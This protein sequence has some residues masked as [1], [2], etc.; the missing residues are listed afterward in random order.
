MIGLVIYV[1]SA[2]CSAPSRPG[3]GVLILGNSISRES[4]P[5]WLDP[6]RYILT[7]ILFRDMKSRAWAVRGDQRHGAESAP[8][9]GL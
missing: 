9:P 1:V 4:A 5:R 6:A 7:T 8:P 2:P 3:L